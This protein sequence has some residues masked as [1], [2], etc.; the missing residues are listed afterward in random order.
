[1]EGEQEEHALPVIFGKSNTAEFRN[2]LI[3]E[4]NLY[5]HYFV[6]RDIFL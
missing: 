5:N 4:M 1:M 2:T 3:H 6:K